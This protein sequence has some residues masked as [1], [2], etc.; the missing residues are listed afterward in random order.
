VEKAAI[1]SRTVDLEAS[2]LQ[3]YIN[4]MPRLLTEH[5]YLRPIGELDAIVE[6]NGFYGAGSITIEGD[7]GFTCAGLHVID[8]SLLVY[9]YKDKFMERA[10]VDKSGGISAGRSKFVYVYACDFTGLG[11]TS[12]ADAVEADNA[13]CVVLS[14]ST[15]SRYSAAVQAVRSSV[16]SIE[17]TCAFSENKKGVGVVNGGVV[18]LGHNIPDTLGGAANTK[19]GGLIVKSDGTLL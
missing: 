19:Y 13:T 10:N 12:R 4:A 2:E 6:L 14:N 15:I 11:E 5:L 8:C 1:S 17:E 7:R 18:L 3:A 9:V 16:L